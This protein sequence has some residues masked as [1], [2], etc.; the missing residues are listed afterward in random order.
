ML[1]EAEKEA[2][3]RLK[4]FAESVRLSPGADK[5]ALAL[6]ALDEAQSGD[7]VS[8]RTK[9]WAY[10]VSVGLPPLGLFYA[11]WAFF[12]KKKDG[13]KVARNC[14]ILTAGG[15]LLAW[16]SL[17]LFKSVIPSSTMNQLQTMSPS[18]LK[19]LKDILQ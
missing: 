18:D 11:A 6:A 15:L 5:A 14:V 8:P 9:K 10:L 12:S 17:A 7:R 1:T 19:D 4:D 2:A 13:K 3:V 16:V